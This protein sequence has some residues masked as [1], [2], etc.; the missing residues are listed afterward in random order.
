MGDQLR[1]YSALPH[2][3][4]PIPSI[5]VSRIPLSLQI[6]LTSALISLHV[7]NIHGWVWYEYILY[8]YT[9]DDITPFFLVTLNT[10]Y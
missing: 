4:I 3:A 2:T 7:Y 5:L 1:F 8:V 9:V 10:I 6:F